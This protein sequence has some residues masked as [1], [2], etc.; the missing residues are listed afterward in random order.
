MIAVRVDGH[1]GVGLSAGGG[2]VDPDFASQG[3][4]A[5]VIAP[6]VDPFEAAI[7]VDARPGNDKAPIGTYSHFRINLLRVR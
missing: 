5:G 7:L 3:V 4:A 6:G 2:G 1:R